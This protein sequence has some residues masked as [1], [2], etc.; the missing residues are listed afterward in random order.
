MPSGGTRIERVGGALVAQDSHRVVIDEH[1]FVGERREALLHTVDRLVVRREMRCR[2]TRGHA[3]RGADMQAERRRLVE[4]RRRFA[5]R[6]GQFVTP[7]GRHEQ[8]EIAEHVEGALEAFIGVALRR[9]RTDR[10]RGP[11]RQALLDVVADV[12]DVGAVALA[13][14]QFLDLRVHRHEGSADPAIEIGGGVAHLVFR[15]IA[16][17]TVERGF[18]AFVRLRGRAW[19]RRCPSPAAAIKTGAASVTTW[20]RSSI[21]SAT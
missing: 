14:I 10:A 5:C 11:L 15:E 20:Q 9:E 1:K 3:E 7:K 2:E 21:S 17:H 19:T 4:W 13:E 16:R 18:D 8:A 6:I 12:I